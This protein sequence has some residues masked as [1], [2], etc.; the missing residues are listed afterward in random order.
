MLGPGPEQ[1]AE[2]LPRTLG[3]VPVALEFRA[4]READLGLARIGGIGPR[5]AV[6][7]QLAGSAQHHR[8][9]EPLA[10]RIRVLAEQLA[11]QPLAVG[12]RVRRVPVLVT[13]HIRVGSIGHEGRQVRTREAPQ[14]EAARDQFGEALVRHDG[15]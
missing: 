7:D 8:V 1:V 10:G 13:G 3:R 6:T 4:E 12:S 14:R 2:Q 15:R 5:R 9:L 11:D